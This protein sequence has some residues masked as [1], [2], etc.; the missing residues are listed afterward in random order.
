MYD[1]F[2]V[3][4]KYTLKLRTGQEGRYFQKGRKYSTV[5]KGT[6]LG[7]DS[8]DLNSCFKLTS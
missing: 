4:E 2:L 6:D 5:V 3:L 7:L 1:L 8:L